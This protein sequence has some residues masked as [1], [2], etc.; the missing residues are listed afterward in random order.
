VGDSPTRFAEQV[1]RFLESPEAFNA[2]LPALQS[3]IVAEYTWSRRADELLAQ[4]QRSR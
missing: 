3:R 2:R 1:L 4:L